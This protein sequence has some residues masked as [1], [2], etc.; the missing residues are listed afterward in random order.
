MSEKPS[1]QIQGLPQPLSEQPWS[2]DFVMQAIEILPI[3]LRGAELVSLRPEH[4]DSFIIA[5]P[6]A[7]KPEEVSA[8]ALLALGLRPIVLH[9]TSW[10]HAGPEVILTYLAVVS[11]EAPPES[12][13]EEGIER[14]ELARG[15]A[16]SP[17]PAIGVAQVLE[18]ALRHLAWLVREDHEIAAALPGWQVVLAGYVP[19]PFR[20]FAGQT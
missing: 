4:S 10:R 11:P 20:P 19:E 16:T 1:E 15:E 12:W 2:T 13:L 14:A 7:A 3:T 17:P 9:S 18:H 6:A 5:W 8:S